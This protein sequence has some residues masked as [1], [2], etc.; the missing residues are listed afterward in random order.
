MRFINLTDISTACLG[1]SLCE[2]LIHGLTHQIQAEQNVYAMQLDGYIKNNPLHSSFFSHFETLFRYIKP[3]YVN[4]S[5]LDDQAI[6]IDKLLEDEAIGMAFPVDATYFDN[7]PLIYAEDDKD[8]AGIQHPRHASHAIL[9]ELCLTKYGEKHLDIKAFPQ[10]HPWGNGGWYH[11]CTIP[12]HAHVKMRLFD[13]RGIFA[14]DPYYAFFK[15]DYMTKVR[16]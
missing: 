14:N 5:L 8:V 11:A 10:L 16:L 15:Y 6:T 2:M 3:A 13:I 1:S 12:F 7:F 4:P 9:K